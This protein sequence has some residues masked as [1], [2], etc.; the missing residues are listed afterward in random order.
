MAQAMRPVHIAPLATFRVLFGALMTYGMLRFWHKDWIAQ[1]YEAPQLFFKFYGLE[2]V[3]VPGG[4]GLY[5]LFGVATVSAVGV[6]LGAF[7]RMSIV[8]FF[9]SFTY[10]ELMDVTN[11][12]N[13]YYLVCLL[14]FLM[15]WLP[16][17]RYG[18]VDAW[19]KPSIRR[20]YVPAWC[21][22][23]LQLQLG[24]VYIYAGVAK[25][26]ADWLLRGMPLATWLPT[27]AHWPVIG[28]LLA[29]PWV[30]IAMSWAGALYDLTITFFL[31]SRRTRAL[32]YLA[33]V[34]FHMLTW[35]M[36][37]IGL[38]P[39]IMMVSTLV[40][41]SPRWHA[42]V[43]GG[44]RRSWLALRPSI[45]IVG[46][47]PPTERATLAVPIARY[48]YA[49]PQEVLAAHDDPY[50][51]DMASPR[52]TT[53]AMR[54]LLVV[55]FAVQLVLPLRAF[56]YPGNL[57]W[58]EQG[59]RFSWRVMLVEKVGQATFYVTDAA[60]GRRAEVVNSE[61]L[62]AWQEKNVSIQ[63]DLLLQYARY[64]EQVYGQQYD[65]QEP[66]VTADVYVALNGRPAHRLVDP[67]APLNQLRDTWTAKPW[68]LP[69]PHQ[70]RR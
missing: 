9:M 49:S 19:R 7:Y 59:Y 44:A 63:P 5:L 23:V 45:P 10:I 53:Y 57:L 3:T 18:S 69:L 50:V 8:T 42:R 51:A 1:L 58:H 47:L 17:H 62:T 20:A 2:W 39:L 61:H 68:I 34:A 55:F 38:F 30:A 28:P 54:A 11:Y 31:L 52:R 36:F 24:I 37:N 4:V 56:A 14:A 6:M 33:V 70:S 60:T 43:W 25:L 29:L 27:K 32:A 66:I 41:F 16:A 48:A 64:L 13:H 46:I 12:L 15:C 26:R 35:A 65:M 22:Y 40:F 21:L 67:E